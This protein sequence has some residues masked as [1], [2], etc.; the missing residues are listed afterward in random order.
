MPEDTIQNCPQQDL[1]ERIIMNEVNK[2]SN[3]NTGEGL[4]QLIN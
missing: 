2:K 4:N 3:V 1:K